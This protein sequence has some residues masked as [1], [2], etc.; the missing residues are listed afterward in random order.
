MPQ[1]KAEIVAEWLEERASEQDKQCVPGS[2]VNIIFRQ[3]TDRLRSWA[4]EAR[5][6]HKEERDRQKELADTKVWW[7]TMGTMGSS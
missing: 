1:S 2:P 7:D 3:E 6:Q 5:R 4:R